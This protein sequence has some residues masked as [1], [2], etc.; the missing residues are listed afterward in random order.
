TPATPAPPAP[1]APD[2]A[3]TALLRER[4]ADRRTHL[5]SMRATSARAAAAL[6]RY[7]TSLARLAALAR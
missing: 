4:L 6:N 1:P 5:A 3:A 2:S 7:R